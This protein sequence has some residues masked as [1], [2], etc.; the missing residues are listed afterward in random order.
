MS[1]HG[2]PVQRSSHTLGSRGLGAGRGPSEPDIGGALAKCSSPSSDPPPPK[3]LGTHQKI[4]KLRWMPNG[5]LPAIGAAK[6][7][8]SQ[9]RTPGPCLLCVP[10]SVVIPGHVHGSERWGPRGLSR[11]RARVQAEF[12]RMGIMRRPQSGLGTFAVTPA[13]PGT[14][15]G[16]WRP[17][18]FGARAPRPKHRRPF[19]LTGVRRW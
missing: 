13:R 2:R 16:K 4:P 12:G 8:S 15:N 17:T 5:G 6:Q 9:H 11:V 7:A 3:W 10:P 19:H 14:R 1:D 18:P